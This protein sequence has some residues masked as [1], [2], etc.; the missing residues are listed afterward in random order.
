MITRR[1]VRIPDVQCPV[2]GDDSL[3]ERIQK[4]VQAIALRFDALKG[5]PE[6]FPH[7]VDRH[8]ERADL[9][10]KARGQ[11]LIE[12]P[13][14]DLRGRACDARRRTVISEAISSPNSA[15]T[16]TAMSAE[17]TTS[18]WTMPSS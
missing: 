9:V 7:L 4:P 3:L 8:R 15:P 5:R 2:D 17:R 6:P 13:T 18:L 14:F 16:P 12:A 10:V 1:P 11:F